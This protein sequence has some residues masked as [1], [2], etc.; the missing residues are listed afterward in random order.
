MRRLLLLSLTLFLTAC[1]T[2]VLH[3][4][5]PEES[6]KTSMPA[7]LEGY[8]A[9]I[10]FW[11]DEAPDF[12]EQSVK[13]RIRQFVQV[14][15]D[16]RRKNGKFPP[17]HFLA[18]SGGG[19]GGAF[20]AGVLNG[21]TLTGDR[22]EFSIVTGVST[23]ALIAPFAFLGSEFDEQVREAYLSASPETI[24]LRD[25]FTVFDGITG[26]T[27]LVDNLPL[28][29]R[30]EAFLTEGVLAKIATAHR[31]GRRLYISTTNLEAERGVIWDIGEIAI[32]DNPGALKLVHDIMMASSAVPGLFAPGSINVQI[33]GMRYQE[34]HV[35]GGVTAQLVLYPLDIS[36]EVV[37]L[38]DYYN[39]DRTLHIIRNSKVSGEYE[40][41]SPDFFNIT[42]RSI[43]TLIKYQ[44]MGDLFRL[45]FAADRDNI[46]Y[47]LVHI[48]SDFKRS[49][50]TE[51]SNEVMRALYDLGVRSGRNQSTWLNSP[52]GTNSD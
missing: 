46:Q 4:A 31:Q 23:G 26:G 16:Y 36:R 25:F 17:L 11:A 7:R 35:D 12:L 50:T 41:V 2:P 33:D 44:G 6:T 38:L 19:D 9:S 45:H 20:G 47:R 34:L 49:N 51:F 39:L 28:R 22:P 43:L 52:P 10:R 13:E 3:V 30:V 15:R 27:A 42:R 24:Y 32:S 37:E 48:P 1:A 8:P 5:I 18:L 40:A 21:W 29:Q 14:N